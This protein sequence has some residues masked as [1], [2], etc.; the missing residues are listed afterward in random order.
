MPTLFRPRPGDLIRV[1]PRVDSIC[2]SGDSPDTTRSLGDALVH[3]NVTCT[4]VALVSVL[5]RGAG[6]HRRT[7]GVGRLVAPI[8][9]VVCF[10]AVQEASEQRRD[11]PC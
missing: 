7:T 5:P 3:M 10:V 6:R 4:V 2:P 1:S 8:A 11:V 9:K